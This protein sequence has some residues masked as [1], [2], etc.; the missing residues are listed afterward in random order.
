MT[1]ADELGVCDKRSGENVPI[2]ESSMFQSATPS[3]VLVS[4]EDMLSAVCDAH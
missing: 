4:S 1:A 2:F 3:T